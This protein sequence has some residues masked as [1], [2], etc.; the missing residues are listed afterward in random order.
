MFTN[1]NEHPLLVIDRKHQ[2]DIDVRKMCKKKTDV[3]NKK[4]VFDVSYLIGKPHL[5]IIFH[6]KWTCFWKAF[7]FVNIR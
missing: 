2:N 5:K 7:F 6:R 4:K 1:I 3:R